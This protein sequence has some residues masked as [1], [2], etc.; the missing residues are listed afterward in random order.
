MAF[1]LMW[2]LIKLTHAL[3]WKEDYVASKNVTLGRKI[4][5]QCF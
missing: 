2:L 5:K 1:L 4:G 3:T